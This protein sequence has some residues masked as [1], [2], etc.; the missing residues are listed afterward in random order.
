MDGPEGSPPAWL[1]LAQDGTKKRGQEPA[2]SS[3][4]GSSWPF[5]SWARDRGDREV[6]TWTL[7]TLEF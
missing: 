5:S 1:L 6:N 3:R 7:W 4:L 2:R